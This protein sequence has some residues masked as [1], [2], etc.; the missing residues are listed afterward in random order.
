MESNSFQ[1]LPLPPSDPNPNNEVEL[2]MPKGSDSSS[3][4]MG[5]E[6]T[7]QKMLSGVS[8]LGEYCRNSFSDVKSQI[9]NLQD[10]GKSMEEAILA[11]T[12][13]TDALTR[14]FISHQTTAR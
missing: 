3:G 6:N 4:V 13:Q 8:K 11:L 7:M 2:Y 5:I 9:E 1:K 12:N 14:A 10:G